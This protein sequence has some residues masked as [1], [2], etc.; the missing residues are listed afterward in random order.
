MEY[1]KRLIQNFIFKSQ[2]REMIYTTSL[3]MD[4]M[5]QQNQIY[6]KRKEVDGDGR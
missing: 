1:V 5:E 4:K 3:I 6:T 2:R